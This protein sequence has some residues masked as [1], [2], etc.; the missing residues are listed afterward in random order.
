MSEHEDYKVCAVCGL[1][2][3]KAGDGRWFHV[4]EIAGASDHIAIPVERHEVKVRVVCDFCFADVPS[5]EAWMIPSRD[6]MM[7]FINVMSVNGFC[8]CSTCKDLIAADEWAGLIDRAA[9]T[10]LTMNP[11]NPPPEADVKRWLTALYNKLRDN[12]TGPP[13]LWPEAHG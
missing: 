9:K 2:L 6:F 1:V 7:P 5:G 10:H 3:E 13:T 12:L 4:R 8:A 11:L